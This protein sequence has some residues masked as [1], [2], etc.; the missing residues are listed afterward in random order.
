MCK[1]CRLGALLL[2]PLCLCTRRF[3]L[4][5]IW[6]CAIGSRGII[7]KRNKVTLEMAGEKS[8]LQDPTCRVLSD[9]RD[10]NLPALRGRHWC[11][12]G[13]RKQVWCK[14]NYWNWLIQG[15]P[16]RKGHEQR[17]WNLSL[18]VTKVMN[19]WSELQVRKL[20]MSSSECHQPTWAK[21]VWLHT[22]RIC[23]C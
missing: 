14:R 8:S 15:I 23:C 4:K 21:R 16:L 2:P 11:L 17:R 6:L 18:D 22:V 7:G 20:Q 9:V 1:Q 19:L 10:I 5:P 12:S 13:W 3:V